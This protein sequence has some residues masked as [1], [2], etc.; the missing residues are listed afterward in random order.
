MALPAEVR[1]AVP[2]AIHGVPYRVA[3]ASILLESTLL[4]PH[5]ERCTDKSRGETTD[6][7]VAVD[8][9]KMQVA[10]TNSATWLSAGWSRLPSNAASTAIGHQ[11]VSGLV[12]SAWVRVTRVA[13]PALLAVVVGG[14]TRTWMK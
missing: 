7:L 8:A 2:A 4:D 9:A 11:V 1:D 12:R 13:L 6:C 5:A 3:E 10:L 14:R